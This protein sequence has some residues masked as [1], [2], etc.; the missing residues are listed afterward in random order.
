MRI[1]LLS[2]PEYFMVHYEN[3]LNSLGEVQHF[4]SSWSGNRAEFED[5]ISYDADYNFIFR[6]EIV[7]DVVL[8]ELKGIKIGFSSEPYPKLLNDQFE[9]T[10]DSLSRF[11]FF[12]RVN[13]D[14]LDYLFHY[15]EISKRFLEVQGF[16]LSGFRQFPIARSV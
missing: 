13:S 14:A 10:A 1:A 4:D 16:H 3:E 7:P 11:K 12:T 5:I 15:D 2:Q 9:F 6:P 8:E